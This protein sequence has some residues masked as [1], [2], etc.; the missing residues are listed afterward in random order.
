MNE[1]ELKSAE[2]NEA[3]L[4]SAKRQHRLMSYGLNQPRDKTTQLTLEKT[5]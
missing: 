2:M 5:I 3:E 1:A 4:K